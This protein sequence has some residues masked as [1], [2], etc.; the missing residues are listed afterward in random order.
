MSDD[1]SSDFDS[2]FKKYCGERWRLARAIAITESALNPWA[3]TP[4]SSAVGLMQQTVA[5]SERWGNFT[6][7][8]RWLPPVQVRAFAKFLVA[9]PGLSD[10][11]I[12]GRYT[13][14]DRGYERAPWQAADYITK[15][16]SHL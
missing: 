3:A 12:A 1:Y 9:H 11:E 8:L 10:A 6:G 16:R 4:D 2:L 14:G 7:D 13:L 15:V 5:F